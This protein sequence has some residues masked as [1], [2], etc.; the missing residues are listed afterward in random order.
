MISFLNRQ[1]IISSGQFIGVV[2][3]SLCWGFVLG[4]AVFAH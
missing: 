1:I 3:F 2:I 4:A